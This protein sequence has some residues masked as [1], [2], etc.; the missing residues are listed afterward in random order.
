M[1]AYIIDVTNEA[2]VVILETEDKSLL[3]KDEITVGNTQWIVSSVEE[4]YDDFYNII[5]YTLWVY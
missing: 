5:R 3:D 1:S 2:G 4:E